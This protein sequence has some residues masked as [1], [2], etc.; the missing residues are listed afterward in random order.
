MSFFAKLLH[1]S[2]AIVR[3]RYFSA[4]AIVFFISFLYQTQFLPLKPL[5]HFDSI[6]YLDTAKKLY[7]CFSDFKLNNIAETWLHL[8]S[9]P[10]V[11]A[12]MLDGPILPLYSLIPF[13]L[14]GL[15][16]VPKNWLVL[17]ITQSACLGALACT[18]GILMEDMKCLISESKHVK[19]WIGVCI[20]LIIGL[21]PE[22][23]I[24]SSRF[25]TELPA[26]TILS[27]IIL[28]AAKI[29]FKVPALNCSCFSF[30]T[31]FALATI[32][33][34]L[35][36]TLIFCFFSPPIFALASK[37]TLLS[38]SQKNQVFLFSLL[39]IIAIEAPWALYTYQA[40]GHL[41]IMPDRKPL[42]NLATGL[43]LR[44]DGYS[45]TPTA[46]STS[47][48]EALGSPAKIITQT[49]KN[50][51]LPLI[52]LF[53]RKI[54]RII[55]LPWND[56]LQTPFGIPVN[57]TSLIHYYLAI[58]GVSGMIVAITLTKNRHQW[59]FNI[60]LISIFIVSLG[61]IIPFEGISRYGFS[62]LPI[63]FIFSTL[64]HIQLK[65]T[66]FLF[67][68]K[69]IVWIILACSILHT[70]SYTEDYTDLNPA[71]KS[72][73]LSILY[74]L[75]I[76]KWATLSLSAA[77]RIGSYTKKTQR[78]I[79]IFSI[80]SAILGASS[81][82][83]DTALSQ[84][85]IAIS[86]QK[87][88][89]SSPSFTPSTSQER[90]IIFHSKFTKTSKA[91]LSS[92][93]LIEQVYPIDLN[94]LRDGGGLNLGIVN[95]FAE[96]TGS[97]PEDYYHWYGIPMPER[98]Q[99]QSPVGLILQNCMISTS[100]KND[101]STV[102][103]WQ[104]FSAGKLSNNP[105]LKNYNLPLNK[106]E[107][108][109][110]LKTRFLEC[111]NDRKSN[112]IKSNMNPN[113]FIIAAE[114]PIKQKQNSKTSIN[115]LDS[116]LF[117]SIFSQNTQHAGSIII[118]KTRIKMATKIPV[119]ISIPKNLKHEDRLVFSL[120]GLARA[121]SQ[122]KR[123][124]I[125]MTI[126]GPGRFESIAI[127]ATPSALNTQSETQRFEIKKYINLSELPFSPE[128]ISIAFYPHDYQQYS[129]YGGDKYCGKFEI[130]DLLLKIDSP[131]WPRLK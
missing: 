28:L 14:C 56:F 39:G 55:L 1:E 59:L 116:K 97:S 107:N 79:K 104:Y 23:I 115:N 7:D 113:I 20:A 88:F 42:Y 18:I 27:L 30:S 31:L 45:S 11:D 90:L 122:N 6:H 17:A 10:I 114:D 58:T 53:S 102:P 3:L 85:S 46:V 37:L 8:K 4:F 32:G 19:N 87:Q 36:P 95:H 119:E 124:G 71:F 93:N 86:T 130:Q 5:L 80:G 25:L 50:N 69:W 51:P 49:I 61:L 21:I 40:T 35:K 108:G 120:S 57:V 54:S 99:P 12:L 22:A 109:K 123:L 110:V 100:A 105:A 52:S 41:H 63:I 83:H 76:Y 74:F 121:M 62:I 33:F 73:V 89:Q 127:P 91:F 125:A 24:A 13:G 64:W 101:I 68:I 98:F 29:V 26:A 38:H 112:F 94:L 70:N 65:S 82:L 129:L 92:K 47:E 34:L 78:A 131:N 77:T 117:D 111:H 9:K 60:L 43:D 66:S 67:K 2:G 103:D 15:E 126:N 106:L 48:M 96:N 128:T 84:A 81:A 72:A 16:P 75:L 44:T 118:D